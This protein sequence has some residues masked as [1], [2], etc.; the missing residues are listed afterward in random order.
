MKNNKKELPE[1]VKREAKSLLEKITEDDR[2]YFWND[3]YKKLFTDDH[4]NFMAD[5]HQH[6]KFDFPKKDLLIN[7]EEIKD[8]IENVV[9]KDKSSA[10][11]SDWVKSRSKGLYE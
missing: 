7:S 11:L 3:E 9:N 1:D 5:K 2:N 8:K 4:P 10:F 6:N